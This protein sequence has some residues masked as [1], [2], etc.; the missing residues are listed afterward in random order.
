MMPTLRTLVRMAWTSVRDPRAAARW[1]MAFDMPRTARWQALLLVV[2]LSAIFA[3]ISV[4]LFIR[5]ET[6]VFGGLLLNPWTTSIIQMA[7]LVV[8]VFAIYWIGHA[9][10][11]QG[12]FG[13]A[14]LLVAWL[15]FCMVCLQLAQTAAMLVLPPMASL[16]GVAGFVLFF[17][18]LTHFVAELHGFTSLGQVFVMIVVSMLAL[19]F[20]LSL[21]L[22]LIGITVPGAPVDV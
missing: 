5:A 2:I 18:L 17:W 15:Q 3:Q 7:I 14:I 10:G 21:I 1:V 13:D 8:A 4:T 11:G 19:V 22:T 9:M 20:G 6:V 12:R 16:I